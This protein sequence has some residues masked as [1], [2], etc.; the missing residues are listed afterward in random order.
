[1][2][3]FISF[4]SKLISMVSFIS[5]RFVPAFR[6]GSRFG[7]TTWRCMRGFVKIFLGISPWLEMELNGNLGISVMG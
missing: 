5:F 6:L 2:E 3:A 4:F 7:V 1:M